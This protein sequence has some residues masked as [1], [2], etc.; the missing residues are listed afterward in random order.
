MFF[1]KGRG[2][3][4]CVYGTK[5][6]V[7]RKS[8]GTTVLICSQL[9]FNALDI[10]CQHN[11]QVRVVVH[12]KESLSTETGRN[13]DISCLV[14]C[15]DSVPHHDVTSFAPLPR[16][17][18]IAAVMCVSGIMF[19]AC[20]VFHICKWSMDIALMTHNKKHFSARLLG[21][22]HIDFINWLK[23]LTVDP[24]TTNTLSV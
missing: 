19:C 15:A 7:D 8:L 21:A 14:W 10:S 24:K 5:G 20:A 1:K 18:I 16:V 4:G 13:C 3:C 12:I 22:T 23:Q 6:A 11:H 17:L 9:G 2:R